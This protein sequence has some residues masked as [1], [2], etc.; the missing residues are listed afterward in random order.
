MTKEA[1]KQEAE[2]L[3]KIYAEEEQKYG[4]TMTPH[5]TVAFEEGFERGAKWMGEYREQRLR[6]LL[7][8]TWEAA[9]DYEFGD[10]FGKIPNKF[11]DK[12]TFI[13]GIFEHP[14]Y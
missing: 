4:H 14:K 10:N 13:K 8:R 7:E 5:V 11:P 9:R 12:E 2:R 3:S 6:E 1:I